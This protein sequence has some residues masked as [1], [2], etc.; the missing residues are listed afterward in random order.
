MRSKRGD[1]I[2]SVYWFVI[3]FLVAGAVVYMVSIFYG[4]P[5]DVRTIEAEILTNQIANCISRGGYL[6]DISFL[7]SDSQEVFFEEC[8]LVFD[9]EDTYDW[10]EQEQYYAEVRVYEFDSESTTSRGEEI[11]NFIVGN[12]NLKTAFVIEMAEKDESKKDMIVIHYTAGYSG[13]G[14]IQ[15]L[16]ANDLSIQY[17]IERDGTVI[18]SANIDELDI[19]NGVDAFK[20]EDE[21]AQHVGCIDGRTGEKRDACQVK[22]ELSQGGEK[23]CIDLN[24]NSI[25]I[26]LV[27]L[28]YLCGDDETCSTERGMLISEEDWEAYVLERYDDETKKGLVWEQFT[29]EQLD[30]LVDLISEIVVRHNIPLD[31]EHIIGHDEASP[32]YKW[33]PGPAFPWEEF[34]ERLKENTRLDSSI[35]KEFYVLD[36]AGN[37][38]VVQILAIV[39]KTEKNVK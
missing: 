4:A 17:M 32:G 16:I 23:C 15:S 8:S 38:Y 27:N 26:E 11:S 2:I 19:E 5:Y 25:G 29:E 37:Q 31:R 35:G 21:T 1:K 20:E 12:S 6:K 28:G 36:N 9:T 3:L 33:D 10:A 30:S 24:K 18:S 22:N 7:N 14:A 34:M 39:G 13:D